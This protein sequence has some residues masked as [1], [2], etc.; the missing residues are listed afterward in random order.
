MLGCLATGIGAHLG[1]SCKRDS[2]VASQASSALTSERMLQSVAGLT[3]LIRIWS[4]N[5][6]GSFG[7]VCSATRI[8]A[9]SY[10]SKLLPAAESPSSIVRPDGCTQE[11]Y[12]QQ[13]KGNSVRCRSERGV[14]GGVAQE[15]R[16]RRS[17]TMLRQSFMPY[18]GSYC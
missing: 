12:T 3:A 6:I 4:N 5:W 15:A 10:S 17:G 1:A 16:R 13:W 18:T 2:A 11:L 14:K 9:A 7:S 8:H